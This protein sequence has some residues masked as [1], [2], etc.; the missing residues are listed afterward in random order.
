M[1]FFEDDGLEGTDL[2]EKCF[3]YQGDPR[4]LTYKFSTHSQADRFSLNKGEVYLAFSEE[5]GLQTG[6]H[7][8]VVSL[9]KRRTN[10]ETSGIIQDIQIS[11]SSWKSNVHSE[12]SSN[13]IND[14]QKVILTS[15]LLVDYFLF[16]E[17]NNSD[18]H[19]DYNQLMQIKTLWEGE[20]SYKRNQRFWEAFPKY[21]RDIT[22]LFW[23]E[24]FYNNNLIRRIDS[25]DFEK[26]LLITK[27]FPYL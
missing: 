11:I 1:S 14:L 21:Y 6:P 25:I 17:S 9:K 3:Y 12:L 15:K 5:I 4:T 2:I 13:N 16:G 8:P 24:K 18:D 20:S 27:D 19:L 26:D 7:F 22:R 23:S 10:S